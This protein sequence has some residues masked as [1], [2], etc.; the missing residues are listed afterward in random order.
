MT[1]I[2]IAA[3]AIVCILIGAG[4]MHFILRNSGTVEEQALKALDKAAKAAAKFREPDV[5]KAAADAARTVR[6]AAL[7]KSIAE[8]F[9]KIVGS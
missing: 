1:P 2:E 9:D 4:L 7:R 5:A 3:L 6:E 8:S